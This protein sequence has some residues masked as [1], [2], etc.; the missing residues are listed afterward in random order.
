MILHNRHVPNYPS[1]QAG[2]TLLEATIALLVLSI[3]MLGISGL[4]F[5][6]LK[7]GRTDIYRT[8]A[9]YLAADMADR[10]RAN[11]LGVGAYADVGANGNCHDDAAT[12]SPEE[13]A[14]EDKLEWAANMAEHMPA[15]SDATVTVANN[16]VTTTYTI[17][18][19]WPE[20]GFQDLVV[21]TLVVE[22]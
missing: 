13:I 8:T 1:Q 9:I 16:A 22:Q 14:R 18:I 10:I 7:S 12:C 4:F 3:G 19:A 2:F 20:P 11:P 17:D 5:E 21:Y 6:G 15:G